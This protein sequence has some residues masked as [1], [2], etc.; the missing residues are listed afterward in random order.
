MNHTNSQYNFLSFTQT[1]DTLDRNQLFYNSEIYSLQLNAELMVL[2]MCDASI[3]KL[4]KGEGLMGMARGFQYAG[5]PS[6]ITTLWSIDDKSSSELMPRFYKN[7]RKGMTKD[8]ALRE[9]QLQLMEDEPNY[10]H[11]FYWGAF[12]PIGDMRPVELEGA[13]NFRWVFWLGGGV[14]LIILVWRKRHYGRSFPNI[15]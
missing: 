11:P 13:A 2:G 9:A 12:V 4:Q 14:L 5:V 1:S 10:G 6:L 15:G 3:G 7:L 8:E